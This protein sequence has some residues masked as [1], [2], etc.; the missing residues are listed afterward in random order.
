[1]DYILENHSTALIYAALL[2][3]L[4]IGAPSLIAV[5]RGLPDRKHILVLNAAGLVFF[6]AWFGALAWACTGRRDVSYYDA[7]LRRKWRYLGLAGGFAVLFVAFGG[8]YAGSEV[9]AAMAPSRTDAFTLDRVTTGPIAQEI[10]AT[11]RLRPLKVVQVSSQASGAVLVVNVDVNDFVHEGDVIARIDPASYEARLQQSQAQLARARAAQADA[12]AT[13]VRARANYSVAQ[14]SASRKGALFERGFVTRADLEAASAGLADGSA[15][16][17]QSRAS[18]TS[19]AAMVAQ[20]ES[21]LRSAKLDL[22]RTYIRSP[23]TGTIMVRRVEPGQTV[24]SSFQTTTLF[25]IAEDLSRMRVEAQVDEADIGRVRLGQAASFTVDSFPDEV[26]RGRVV[27][28]RKSPE[29]TQGAVFY[30]VWVEVMNPEEKLLSG[31]T[32]DVRIVEVQKPAA[33][34]VPIAALSF[35]P[36]GA[37]KADGGRVYRLIDARPVPVPVKAGVRNERWAEIAGSGLRAG[38]QIIVSAKE[39]LE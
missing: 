28:I 22:E 30:P 12:S 35:Q 18:L 36:A 21:E 24:V 32:A 38:D 16:I 1:M 34:R 6:S 23:V 19:A 3:P 33:L 15:Q 7:I 17:G 2:T 25:E 10:T 11:G 4:L 29:E 37:P 39:P 14:A 20:A 5:V 13:G 27:T 9:Y 26:F 31:M 8:Y